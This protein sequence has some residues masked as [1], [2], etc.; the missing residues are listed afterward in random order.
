MHGTQRP[1][2]HRPHLDDRLYEWLKPQKAQRGRQGSQRGAARKGAAEVCA[3][4]HGQHAFRS[5]LWCTACAVPQLRRQRGNRE[6][7]SV[8]LHSTHSMMSHA[9]HIATA[10]SDVS[11]VRSTMLWYTRHNRSAKFDYSLWIL[12]EKIGCTGT[13]T[14]N[15]DCRRRPVQRCNTLALKRCCVFHEGP[16]SRLCSRVSRHI[17]LKQQLLWTSCSVTTSQRRTYC[18]LRAGVCI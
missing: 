3:H 5:V 18:A 1:P 17:E 16:A 14:A 6:C 4:E 9:C 7:Q 12:S 10:H 13:A 15:R 2:Q 8:H 11:M